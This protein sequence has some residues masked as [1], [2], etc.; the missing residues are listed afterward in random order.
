M[1]RYSLCASAAVVVFAS[2]TSAAQSDDAPVTPEGVFKVWRERQE[3]LR[4]V[5]VEWTEEIVTG[6]YTKAAIA[7]KAERARSKTMT[8]SDPGGRPETSAPSPRVDQADD[9][10][11]LQSTMTIAGDDFRYERTGYVWQPMSNA[12]ERR[13]YVALGTAASSLSFSQGSR[14]MGVIFKNKTFRDANNYHLLPLIVNFRPLDS[15]LGLFNAGHWNVRKDTAVVNDVPCVVLETNEGA[16]THRCWLTQDGYYLQRYTN[17][18]EGK[19]QLAVNCRH[20]TVSGRRVV[21]S[22]TMTLHAPNTGD[23]REST[24]ATVV[25]VRLNLDLPPDAFKFEFPAGTDVRD[26]RDEKEPGR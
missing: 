17:S 23:L 7:S 4:T 8:E 20:K 26:R 3:G 22:W 25:D 21:G 13:N 24:T 15:R 12:K 6:E 14:P 2:A 9:R 18:F 10:D 11:T 19:L 1:K 16:V 5:R